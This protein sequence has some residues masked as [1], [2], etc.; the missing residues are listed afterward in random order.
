MDGLSAVM[1]KR[2]IFPNTACSI[3]YIGYRVLLGSI[4]LST[5]KTKAQGFGLIA[6]R[7]PCR[8]GLKD[9]KGRLRKVRDYVELGAKCPESPEANGLSGLKAI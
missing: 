5:L 1:L 9:Q 6:Q 2:V 8:A 3:C 4:I 7:N